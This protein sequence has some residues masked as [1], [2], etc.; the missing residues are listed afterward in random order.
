MTMTAK[1]EPTAARTLC[2]DV[3]ASNV[4]AGVAQGGRLIYMVERR[5]PDLLASYG[6]DMVLAL[7]E[8]LAEV[9]A[10]TAEAATLSPV[11]PVGPIGVGVPAIV[12]DGGS[13]RIG[14]SSGL[15]AGTALRDRLSERFATHVVVDNDASLAALGEL[16]YGAGVGESSLALLTLGTNIGMGIVVD[17]R[18]Y[19]GAHGAAGEI[20][21][22]PLRLGASPRWERVEQRR[23]GLDQRPPP[24]GYA[25][26]E[27]VYGGQA[28]ADAWRAA[29]S[30]T[31]TDSSS[32]SMP[33]ALQLATAGDEVAREIVAEALQG[34]ALAVATTCGVL[35][36]S[37]VLLGGG[38]AADLGPYLDR[39]RQVVETFMPGR[40]PRIEMATLGPSAGLIGAAAA[41]RLSS[42]EAE[43]P[44]PS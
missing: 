7:A 19:R 2:A 17:G 10:S 15:P 32:L 21:T 33:R 8:V 36:P 6:G 11:A 43:G 22:V 34:W 12:L 28:L 14:L 18:I 1:D 41:A 31:E 38:I 25:W 20:G 23:R 26:L 3:G 27:E 37:V 30:T 35:D 5:I 16:L 13:L 40:P 29:A 4:R 9:Q 24:D 42:G 44:L 39:L